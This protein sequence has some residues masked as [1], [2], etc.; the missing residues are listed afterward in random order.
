M[1]ALSMPLTL[2]TAI[3]ADSLTTTPRS[4][5]NSV[6][7]SRDISPTTPRIEDP[8]ASLK[9]RLRNSCTRE[10]LLADSPPGSG[11]RRSQP[12]IVSTLPES[13][14]VVLG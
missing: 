13:K 1:A 11:I 8:S 2:P 14:K 12:V 4:R 7:V 9:T 3:S 5:R 10:G 6:V